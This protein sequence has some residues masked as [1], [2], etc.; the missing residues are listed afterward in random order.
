M[1]RLTRW[2]FVFLFTVAVITGITILVFERVP[3]RTYGVKQYIW[4]GGIVPEDC[5]TGYH[6]GITG[7]HKWH[8]L[9]ASTHFLEFVAADER[10]GV[11]PTE[12]SKS[13]YPR[14]AGPED[15]STP[16]H[17]RYPALEIRNRDGNVVT[18]DISVPYQIIKGQAHRLVEDGLK[19]FYQERVKATVES[20]LREVLPEMSNDALIDLDKRLATSAKA[21]EVLQQKLNQFHVRA[22]AV[23]I[24]RVAFPPEYE[25]KLQQKQLFTQ[26]A[27]LNQADTL[28]LVEVLRTGTIEKEIAAAEALSL[29]E[30]EKKTEMLR[31]EYGIQVA[32]IQ[33]EALQYSKKT[34][35]EADAKSQVK[36]ADGKLA[37]D[38][39]EA[40]LTQLRSEALSTAGG[41][42]YVA[43][44]AAEN[45]SMGRVTINS[46]DPR[47]PLVLEIHRFAE[48]LLGTPRASPTPQ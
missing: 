12:T 19:S 31:A 5:G 18:I 8:L 1:D 33:S 34:R 15:L 23:L 4:A 21:L 24:R 43:R 20:V 11:R 22:E 38:K 42:I 14:H 13:L 41:Q 36:I 9:D 47:G 17:D 26:K 7:I 39:A 35:A 29:A 25:V 30:W 6:L 37:I 28:K 16:V 2:I 3:V 45:L 46:S 40:L 48:M 27:R 32:T 44:Q 10:Q